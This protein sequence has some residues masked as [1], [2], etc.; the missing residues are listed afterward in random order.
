MSRFT[1]INTRTTQMA[2]LWYCLGMLTMAFAMAG[3]PTLLPHEKV[4]MTMNYGAFEGTSGM[5]LNAAFRITDAVQLTGGIG[6]GTN[7]HIAGGRVGLRM[8]W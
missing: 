5:A 1:P 7:E 2:M 4:A 3:V 8:G 6:Y